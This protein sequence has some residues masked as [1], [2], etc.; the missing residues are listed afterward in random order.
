MQRSASWVLAFLVGVGVGWLGRATS[1]G[2]VDP[3]VRYGLKCLMERQEA[4]VAAARVAY[5]AAPERWDTTHH[6]ALA[7]LLLH[8][9]QAR[10]VEEQLPI[11]APVPWEPELRHLARRSTSLAR[12]PREQDYSKLLHRRI[13]RELAP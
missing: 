7:L 2:A 9:C 10:A 4:V 8:S 3:P 12:T 5:E 1:L 13:K 6:L 11:G